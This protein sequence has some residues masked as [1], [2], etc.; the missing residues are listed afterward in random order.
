MKMSKFLFVSLFALTLCVKSVN[1]Q[2]NDDYCCSSWLDYPV[3]G[4]ASIGFDYFRSIPEGSYEGNSGGFISANFGAPLPFL[5]C[6][7][8][9]MQ[10]GGSY[11]VYDW[12]G[13]NSVDSNGVQQ[14]FFITTGI[15][16]QAFCNSD[17]NFGLVFDDMIN[18]NFGELAESPNLSQ[19]RFQVGYLLCCTDEFGFWGT[20]HTN[21]AHKN[22]S[23]IGVRYRAINQINLFWRHFFENCAYTMVWAG[24]PYQKSLMSSSGRAGNYIVGASFS[25][26]LN[27]CFSIDGHASYMGGRSFHSQFR[28]LNYASNVCIALTYAFGAGYCGCE[29]T[30]SAPYLPVANN[31]NF[32]ADT[33]LNY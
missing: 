28:S 5:S 23:G 7:G 15:S 25:V 32:L 6:Y 3:V 17:F 14:Q 24:T 20:A 18:K 16:G 29:E 21:T 10:L 31:S 11:G 30:C 19:I 33:S 26:P 13:R 4:S 9:D 1:A 27:H 8:L 2:M 22:S 12:D